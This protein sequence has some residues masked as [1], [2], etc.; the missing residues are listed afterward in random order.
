M[1]ITKIVTISLITIFL[2]SVTSL[3]ADSPNSQAKI[4][5][6]SK[7]KLIDLRQMHLDVI[8]YGDEYFEVIISP[9]RLEDVYALGYQ[10]DII[11]ENIT[12]F[13]Q[14]RM[15]V[16]KDMGGYMTLSEIEA[17]I[18]SLVLEHSNI[19]SSKVSL[20]LTIE[21]R[22]IWAVKISDNPNI[23]EDEPEVLYTSAI[24]AREV[25]TPLVL[26]HFSEHLTENYGIDPD[27]DFLV[28]NREIWLVFCVNP[29]GYYHNEFTDPNGG[30]M[31]RKNR[32]NNGDGT[33]GVDLN[34]NWGYEWGHDNEG[35]SPYGY[36]ETYRGTG[37]FSEIETQNMRDFHI[38]H[39]FEISIYFHSHSNINIWPWGYDYLYTP[40]NDLYSV[41]GDSISSYNGYEPGT[42]WE[43]IHYIANGASDDWI[44]GEQLIKNKT[45][46]MTIEVGNSSDGFW[47]PTSRIPQLISE[48]LGALL[49]TTNVAGNIYSLRPPENPTLAVPDS[50][51]AGVD[52]TIAWQLNDS[53]NPAVEYELVELTDHQELTDDAGNFDNCLNNDFTVSTSRYNSS[54]S[55]FFSGAANDI[56]R[57]VQYEM[58]FSVR[59]G[60]TLRLMTWYDI[61]TNWDYAYVEVSTDGISYE[62]IE[63][64]ITT[65][66]NPN[67]TNRGNGI[68]GTSS[69]WI[70]GLFNLSQFA[71]EIISIRLSYDTDSYTTDEGIYFDDIYPIDIFTSENVIPLATADTSYLMTGKTEGEYYYKVRAKDAEEQWSSYSNT[72]PSLVYLPETYICGD[73]NRD[74]TVNVS[75]AVYL[76]NY[77]F[78]VSSPAPN[79]MES[80][81]V[82]CDGVVNVSDAVWIINYIF[83]FGND[84]CDPDGDHMPDC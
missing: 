32:R 22:D 68:T 11:H 20:G 12:Q 79:P 29:D 43:A 25:I 82:N 16:D 63:G 8:E 18:D 39:E 53:L 45:F 81:D 66:S 4:Y 57:Y 80:G 35:S 56:Y 50:V 37:P 23:D 13:Y 33:Y 36:D 75:D 10:V 69:G 5:F 41:M 59:T 54:P 6:D 46:A 72:L 61:E 70:Q 24:H 48:N 14:S 51:E 2:I 42:V 17:Y 83:V 64:N 65:S 1:H 3:S 7:E 27:V 71:G 34:R 19:V 74:E 76:V 62:T 47:P 67:G 49:Y 26:R 40:D 9:E 77:I 58:P 84:P 44:Y 60:D 30:G 21:G 78:V 55:S 31:W 15:D 73:A 52:F 28:D 38:A